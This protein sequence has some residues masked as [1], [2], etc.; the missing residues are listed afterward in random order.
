MLAG[1]RIGTVEVKDTGPFSISQFDDL[2]Q[3]GQLSITC[4][5]PVV[6]PV[7]TVKAWTGGTIYNIGDRVSFNGKI[8]EARQTHTSQVG[9]EPPNVLSLWQLPTPTGITFWATQ[10][11]YIVG[12]QVV[13][14]AVTYRAVQEHVSQPDWQPPTTPTLW[15]PL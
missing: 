15:Q 3:V 4:R 9:W 6:S 7:I 12:S 10:T 14:A 11:H 5:T 8:F 1:W 2:R 13:F